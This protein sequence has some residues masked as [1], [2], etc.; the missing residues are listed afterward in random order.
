M[1]IVLGAGVVIVQVVEVVEV[2]GVIERPAV[3]LDAIGPLLR[4]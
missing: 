3:R 1:C 2:V 4:Q